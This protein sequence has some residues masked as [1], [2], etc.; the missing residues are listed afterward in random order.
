MRNAL[1]IWKHKT[2]GKTGLA[3]IGILAL[4]LFLLT[5]VAV[6]CGDDDPVVVDFP[7]SA[8]D[9]VFSVTGDGQVTICWN[10]NPEGDIAGYDIYWNS[11]PTGAFEFIGSVGANQTCFVD[12][13]VTNGTTYYYAVAAFDRAGLDS[14]LSFEDVFD[15]PRPEGANLVLSAVG[16][17]PSLS[18]YDFSLLSGIPQAWSDPG[19]D[20]YF[21]SPNPGEFNLIANQAGGV[22]IQDYGLI[23]LVDVDWA[24]LAG[25]SAQGRVELIQGHS[26]IVRIAQGGSW[27]MAKINVVVVS[28]NSVTLDWAYQID[29]GNPELTPGTGGASR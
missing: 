7:P 2:S 21:D 3:Y 1:R 25:W 17:N 16:Q 19:T 28:A 20:V 13:D 24:P 11:A 14:E 9:G 4:G 8:P 12:T 15:T 26:Y 29:P 5:L 22:D 18:G 27:N 23:D 10:A 6:G